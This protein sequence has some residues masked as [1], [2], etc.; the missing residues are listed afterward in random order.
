MKHRL[1]KISLFLLLAGTPVFV[2]WYIHC[3]PDKLFKDPAATILLD[4]QGRLLAAQIAADG[5]WRMEENIKVPEKFA[6]CLL[7]YED[8]DF[9]THCG[10]SFKA[11]GRALWQNVS[12]GRV[13]SGGS[14]ITM[15]LM[16]LQ[17]KNPG[18]TYTEKLV[19]MVYAT[20]L[21]LRYSKREILALYA[22]HAPFGSN[23]VGLDAAAWR[24]FG[25]GAEQ[26]SWAENATLAVLPNAPGLIYPGKNH[27]RLRAKRN[28]LLLHLKEKGILD[29][30]SYELALAEPLPDKP[31]PLPKNAP[32][33]LT[34]AIK[35]GN[36]GKI[37][38]TTIDAALQEKL[39]QVLDR[40]HEVLQENGI[41][42]GAILVASVR[43][44]Q[45]RAYIGN[46][47]SAGTVNENDVDII[48]APR[49][50]GSTLKPLLYAKMLDEGD[51]TPAM[52]IPDVPTQLG[53]YSPKNF[54]SSYDGAVPAQ[55]AL[56]RSL[57]IPAVRMLNEYGYEKFYHNLN[58]MGFST[59]RRPASSYGLSL[60]LGGAEATLWDMTNV[61]SNMAR[62]LNQ[63][64][65]YHRVS[66]ALR[67][68]K[69]TKKGKEKKK[70]QAENPQVMAASV[71][72]TFEAMVE[73]NR[74]DE[75]TNWKT[76]NQQ[77]KIA[78]KTGT[79]FGNRDAWAVGVTPDY[80]VAVWI[81]NADGEGRP[82]LTGIQAAAPVL[83][84]VFKTLPASRWF[85]MPL[86]EMSRVAICSRS[87]HR[88]TALC[89]RT[90]SIYIPKTALSTKAC[91]YHQLI[92][93]DASGKFRVESECEEVERMKH[94]S[95]FVLPPL[96][97]K[98][99]KFN[100]PD[101]KSLPEYLPGCMQKASDKG[102]VL[103]YPKKQ[104]H[105][106]VP[107]QFDGNTG[108]V[109][110]EAAHRNGFTRI[111]WHLDEVFIGTTQGIHQLEYT[112]APGK[113][114]VCIV[115]E[116]G[117]SSSAEFEVVY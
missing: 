24:Y 11:L 114:R 44:A 39:T 86:K 23:V 28:R 106:Y 55:R 1:K 58:R 47:R 9:Y 115:D 25:R 105:I 13:V 54:S 35:D 49:S 41:H 22:S 31:L 14:T 72:C 18:R 46:T 93:L 43:T 33:L 30:M 42:N 87:G 77:G 65:D 62:T 91:P 61:Y 111:F 71:W 107:R 26:L 113:H 63:Y 66:E 68:L 19:E 50:T 92:H 79:S 97:E 99:Y 2:I 48:Q 17:R 4:K 21:E 67:Y 5:Q 6:T 32:H 112:P 84:D 64:P 29:A 100:N 16:R 83:F 102:M 80:V 51:I 104:S 56:A 37:I 38:S 89:E 8:R 40:H 103:V 27:E 74:P 96:M 101:Y 59:I 69:H 10:I 53:A 3:L 110:F 73:V 36:K 88:A 85:E 116:N 57:N 98:Y 90:D 82:G 52:L 70:P 95:W 75:E 15:Q 12:K 109:V 108:K 7:Q 117:I 81:G 78:W 94:A 34:K 76:F 20:R 60:I 45:V